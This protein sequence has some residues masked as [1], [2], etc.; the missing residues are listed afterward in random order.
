MVVYIHD[1]LKLKQI[2]IYLSYVYY[3]YLVADW[4][5]TSTKTEISPISGSPPSSDNSQ[6]TPSPVAAME[7]KSIV[8]GAAEPTMVK[9]KSVRIMEDKNTNNN[10]SDNSPSEGE[11]SFADEGQTK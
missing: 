10:T 5:K 6:Q 4:L 9:K 7:N 8:G 11:V 3:T 2:N 1:T